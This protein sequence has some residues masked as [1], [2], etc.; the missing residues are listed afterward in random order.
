MRGA[1][2]ACVAAVSLAGCAS[3]GV[4]ARESPAPDPRGVPVYH[5]GAIAWKWGEMIDAC[6]GADAVLIGENHGHPLGLASA[7]ALWRDVAERSPKAALA[8]EFFERDDQRNLD[9]Y[10]SGLTDEAQFKKASKRTESSYPPGHRAMVEAAKELGRA[11][12]AANAPMSYVRAARKLGYE[13]LR[14]LSPEQA[15]LF[16]VPDALPTGRYREAFDE[17]MG[18][19]HAEGTKEAA[20]EARARLDASFRSQSLWDWTMA[21]TVSRAME[22][23]HRPTVLVV[24]RFHV[25]HGGGLV[26]ALKALS[27]GARVVVVSYVDGDEPADRSADRDRGDFVIYVGT[28]GK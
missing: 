16:R 6:A 1:L 21:E 17:V 4:V 22:A 2:A 13:K 9:D 5:A 12:Y 10:L 19:A 27:P 7:A 26:Q 28:S 14:G 23:G 15:R 8:L 11:V 25:D 24:G 3:R 18:G 20:E